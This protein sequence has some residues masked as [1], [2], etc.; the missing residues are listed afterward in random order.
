MEVKVDPTDVVERPVDGRGRVSVGTD[1]AGE[2][3]RVAVVE[4]VTESDTETVYHC[5]YCDSG[6]A[7]SDRPD[8]CPECGVDGDSLEKIEVQSLS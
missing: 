2:T 6:F 3:V 5:K 1:H 7:V 4:T 8:Q